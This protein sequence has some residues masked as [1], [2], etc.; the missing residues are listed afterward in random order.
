MYHADRVCAIPVFDSMPQKHKNLGEQA[1][2][3]FSLPTFKRLLA[4]KGKISEDGWWCGPAPVAV[5]NLADGASITNLS[6]H[7]QQ[8][9]SK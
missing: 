5:D 6:A 9:S 2:I 1:P 8:A 4:T 7:G 3:I